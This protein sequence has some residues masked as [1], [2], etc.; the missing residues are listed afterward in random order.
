M[1]IF[2]AYLLPHLATVQSYNGIYIYKTALQPVLAFKTI[3]ASG[4]HINTIWMLHNWHAFTTVA[5]SHGH[6]ITIHMLQ[7]WLLSSRI[8]GKH[9][10]KIVS[11]SHIMSCLTTE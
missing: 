3:T 7:K 11:Y 8:D 5:A 1:Q 6:T 2:F 10:S 4:S 9:K